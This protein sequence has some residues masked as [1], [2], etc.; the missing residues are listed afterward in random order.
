MYVL[1]VASCGLVGRHPA[2]EAPRS[3]PGRV[4]GG[5]KPVD[6]ARI[7]PSGFLSVIGPSGLP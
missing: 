1:K 3:Q 7:S 6:T 2:Q 4:G 5:G